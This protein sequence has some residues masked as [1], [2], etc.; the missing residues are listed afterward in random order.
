[1]VMIPLTLATLAA[2]QEMLIRYRLQASG[3]RQVQLHYE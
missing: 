2:S 3:T 1:V